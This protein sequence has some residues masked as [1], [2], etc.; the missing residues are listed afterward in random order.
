MNLKT[1]FDKIDKYLSGLMAP[2]EKSA[3]EERLK[4]DEELKAGLEEYNDLKTAIHHKDTIEYVARAMEDLRKRQQSPVRRLISNSPI[5]AAAIIVVLLGIVAIILWQINPYDKDVRTLAE[6]FT[7]EQIDYT[8]RGD[9]DDI[10]KILTTGAKLFNS[11]NYQ[12]ASEK[13]TRAIEIHPGQIQA[14]Y[15]LGLAKL[16]SGDITSSISLL[17]DVTSTGDLNYTPGA[18]WHLAWCYLQTGQKDRALVLLEQL[19]ED[20]YYGDKV[21]EVIGVMGMME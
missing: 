1:N 10:D 14:K 9:N 12:E 6:C 21:E 4:T 15:Y 3:F 11:E 5:R 17:K 7:P 13:F 20:G 16:Y 8:F 18:K 19:K 2:D